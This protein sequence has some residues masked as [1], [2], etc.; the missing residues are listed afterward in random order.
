M[1][2]NCACS[3]FDVSIRAT[4][5]QKRRLI[6]CASR[7]PMI[8]CQGRGWCAHKTQIT[9]RLTALDASNASVGVKAKN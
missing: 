4:P 9:K 6:R 1:N 3:L 8:H 5:Q 7:V 2:E